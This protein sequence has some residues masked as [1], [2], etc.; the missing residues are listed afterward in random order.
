[1]S[2]GSIESVGDVWR[3]LTNG[4]GQAEHHPHEKGD[5]EAHCAFSCTAMIIDSRKADATT[6][7][8]KAFEPRELA[9]TKETDVGP[10]RRPP[11]H[12]SI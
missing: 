9:G 12:L 3:F 7:L 8:S 2:G 5:H 11:R 10:L 6:D 4:S 1:M